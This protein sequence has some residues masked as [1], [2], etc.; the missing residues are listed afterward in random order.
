MVDGWLETVI[1][2]LG[3]EFLCSVFSGFSAQDQSGV[4]GVIV[5]LFLRRNSLFVAEWTSGPLV[6]MAP[7]IP[8]GE[9]KATLGVLAH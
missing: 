5:A 8:L 7:A 6:F 9:T 2:Y 1:I 3:R 4:S